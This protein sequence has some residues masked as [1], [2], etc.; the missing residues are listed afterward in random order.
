MMLVLNY[1]SERI[2]ISHTFTKSFLPRFSVPLAWFL[3]TTSS[4]HLGSQSAISRVKNT[5]RHTFVLSLGLYAGSKGGFRELCHAR[6]FLALLRLSR[7]PTLRSEEASTSNKNLLHTSCACFSALSL[8]IFSNSLRSSAVSSS[9]S[10]L[11]N[12]NRETETLIRV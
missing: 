4:S 12:M 8:L 7:V 6:D 2:I 5:D 11:Q 9:S 1:S 3:K 10:S